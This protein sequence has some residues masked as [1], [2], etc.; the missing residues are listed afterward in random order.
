MIILL[1]DS[2][3]P[4]DAC[5]SLTIDYIKLLIT[6]FIKGVLNG[7]KFVLKKQTLR[8]LKNTFAEKNVENY[9]RNNFSHP[10]VTL[11]MSNGE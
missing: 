10:K 3:E 2:G 1:I 4:C 9:R 6:K 5:T 11:H 7:C 8:I